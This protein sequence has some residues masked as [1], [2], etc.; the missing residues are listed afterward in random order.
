MRQHPFMP[1]TINCIM[2]LGVTSDLCPM[3]CRTHSFSFEFSWPL[4]NSQARQYGSHKNPTFDTSRLKRR[5]S[6]CARLA[7]ILN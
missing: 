1:D 3:C 7:R 5:Q 2:P 4:S 6:M